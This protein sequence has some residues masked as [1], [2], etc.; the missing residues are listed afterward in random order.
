MLRLYTDTQFSLLVLIIC[1]F[2]LVN[3]SICHCMRIQCQIK[4]KIKFIGSRAGND[5]SRESL[6]N[7]RL[8]TFTGRRL[9]KSEHIFI[10]FAHI[11]KNLT[12]N[13]MA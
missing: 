4:I 1:G 5:S 6:S 8:L 13:V 7:A 2:I 9:I 11:A 3:I 12:T 10:N